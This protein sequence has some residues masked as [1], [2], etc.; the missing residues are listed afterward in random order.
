MKDDIIVIV[1]MLIAVVGLAYCAVQFD[2][3]AFLEQGEWY[4]SDARVDSLDLPLSVQCYEYKRKE[5]GNE[6]SK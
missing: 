5:A 2:R 3:G 1:S 6:Q 4:C